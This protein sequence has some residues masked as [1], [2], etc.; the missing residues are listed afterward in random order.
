LDIQYNRNE[1]I[2][3]IELNENM[4]KNGDQ[5][6]TSALPDDATVTSV[7]ESTGITNTTSA[8]TTAPSSI[9][10]K[11]AL[12][13]NDDN[14]VET[15]VIFVPNIWSLMPNSIEYQQIVEAYKN[16]IENPPVEPEEEE[17]VVTKEDED[18]KM[19]EEQP[20]VDQDDNVKEEA[21]DV[22]AA[23]NQMDGQSD[24]LP[25]VKK[26]E[27]SSVVDDDDLANQDNLKQD[28]EASKSLKALKIIIFL[29]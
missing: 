29:N 3:T 19:D 2:K 13:L 14:D 22:D 7:N 21:N 6:T 8:T 18:Q 12:D 23:E 17:V 28:S 16:F 15:T 9:A 1:E 20:R 4:A 25:L 5:E 27:S 10:Y 24:E 11:A 26:E